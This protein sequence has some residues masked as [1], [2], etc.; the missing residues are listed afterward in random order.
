MTP[1]FTAT[2][3]ADLLGRPVSDE[4]AAAVERVVWGWLKPVLDLQERPNPIPDEVLSWALELAGIAYENP[5]GLT[6]Y[7]LGAERTYFS[8]ERRAQILA[9][10]SADRGAGEGTSPRGSF[11][12]ATRYPD[13]AWAPGAATRTSRSRSR[14]LHDRSPRG[15]RPVAL[16]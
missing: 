8:A 15:G 2:D 7:Q 12:A 10:A 13:P 14:E 5:S 3:L 9:E 6:E 1:L 11:P 16:R 4:R